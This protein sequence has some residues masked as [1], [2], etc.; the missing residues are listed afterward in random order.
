MITMI[1]VVAV[2]AVITMITVVAVVAVIAVV[3]MVAMVAGIIVAWRWKGAPRTIK[4][5]GRAG[6]P[7]SP[8]LVLARMLVLYSRGDRR[9][10]IVS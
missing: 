2:I 4:G 6:S 3:A 1:A 8:N 7:V 5:R 10:G 9:R